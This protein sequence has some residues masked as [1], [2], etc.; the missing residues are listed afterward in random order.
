MQTQCTPG[1]LHFHPL[2]RREVIARFDGG[3]ITSDAGGALLRETDV[4]LGLMARLARCF[5][6]YRKP[7]S[8]EHPVRALVAQRVY[9][10][11][12]GYEDLND[13]EDLRRD[14]LLAL[15]VGKG[16]LTGA[17]R[18][19]LRDR[20]SAPAGSSTLNRLE[21]GGA[22]A[23]RDRYKRIVADPEAMDRLLVDVFMESYAEPPGR[24]GWTSTPRIIAGGRTCARASAGAP[25]EPRN[26]PKNAVPARAVRIMPTMI[27]SARNSRPQLQIRT[28]RSIGEISG[29]TVLNS[30]T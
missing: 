3:R 9:A 21:L 7:G 24:Y 20:G 17:G 26:H 1:R 5:R 13:H 25:K 15:L 4:R 27:P 16:D 10:L 22:G 12:L 18:V 6:D 30:V 23:A 28:I 14:S 8:V 19:R 29:L 2:G 11:A